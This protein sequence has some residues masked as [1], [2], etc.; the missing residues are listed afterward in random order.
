MQRVKCFMVRHQAEGVISAY[1][2]AKPPTEEEIA[3]VLDAVDVEDRHGLTHPKHDEPY[4][5]K[6]HESVLMVPDELA[7]HFEP[8]PDPAAKA[9]GKHGD[10]KGSGN[11]GVSAP[12]LS[13]IGH[14]TN[15]ADQTPEQAKA[16]EEARAARRAEREA[17]RAKQRE[18]AAAHEARMKAQA[19][20]ETM[21]IGA[22]DVA[23]IA[24]LPSPESHA[25]QTEA[26]RAKRAERG[27]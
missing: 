9:V 27:E 24:P 6:I 8:A 13:A 18:A 17:G 11:V 19:G 7:Q 26:A 1:V 15:P 20:G 3:A 4:W 5:T 25:G 22:G 14:V 12:R 10:A 2:F 16:A 23:Q 21:T